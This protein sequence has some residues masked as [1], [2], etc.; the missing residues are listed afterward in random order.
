MAGKPQKMHGKYYTRI[1]KPQGNGKYKQILFPLGVRTK[2]QAE[3][4]LIILNK[5][6]EAIKNGVKIEMPWQNKSSRVEVQ[7]YSVEDAVNEFLA[8]KRAEHLR[9]SSIN[10]ISIALEH[11]MK[12]VGKSM[13]VTELTINQIDLFKKYFADTHAANTMNNNL[14][15][16]GA[17]C[18]WLHERGRLESLPIIRKIRVGKALPQ[19]ITD[20]EWKKIMLL[21]YVDRKYYDYQDRIDEHWKRAFYFYRKTGCRLSEPF[22]GII[23]GNWLVIKAG[24][25]KTNITRQIRLSNDL[26]HIAKEMK[27]RLLNCTCKSRRDHIQAYSKKFKYACDTIGIDKYFH[28]LRH[29][30]AVRRYLQKGDIYL[31]AKELGHSSV[32]TTE[33]YANFDIRRLEDDFPSISTDYKNKAITSNNAESY[34]NHR[35]QLESKPTGIVGQV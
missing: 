19:Y 3:Q 11:F 26:I 27:E 14:S 8:Y 2:A 1:Y 28:C 20:E 24:N 5:Y 30:Y 32:K 15:K 10:R 4:N 13:P 9:Q 33:V 18:R 16:I 22:N 31:V 29:T 34:T 12:V 17:F 35:I 7:T 6:E 21:D 25:S 23:E